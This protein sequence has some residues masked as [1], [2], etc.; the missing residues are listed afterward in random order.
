MKIFSYLTHK[1]NVYA[2]VIGRTKNNSS[3]PFNY[4]LWRDQ[5]GAD[6]PPPQFLP[7][8]RG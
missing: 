4:V 6:C 7:T 1:E 5:T 2:N 3:Y 8:K